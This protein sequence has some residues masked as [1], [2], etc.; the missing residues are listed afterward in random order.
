MEMSFSPYCEMYLLKA[1]FASDSNSG[2][3]AT[4]GH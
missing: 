1:S 3:Q 4:R 2:L